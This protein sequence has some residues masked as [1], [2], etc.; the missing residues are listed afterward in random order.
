M[1]L[2]IQDTLVSDEVFTQKFICNLDACKGACCIEGDRGA[3]IELAEI[4][5][6]ESQIENI[7]PFMDP[8]GIEL[9]NAIGFHEGLEIDDA[10]TTCLETGECVFVYR[11]NGQLGCAIE[12][13]YN[14][15]AIPFNKPISCHLYPIRLGQINEMTTV[16][17]HEWDIC[18]AACQLGKANNVAVYQF[19]KAPLIRRFGEAWYAELEEVYQAYQSTFN[20]S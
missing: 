16:N 17:Y 1:I 2:E 13:A 9:Y 7:K 4:E 18:S 20:R 5:A 15:G 12:K 11:E 6:I 19:L 3:P 10:A 14:S 8:K